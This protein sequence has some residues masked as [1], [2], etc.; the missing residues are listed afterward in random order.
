MVSCTHG[1]LFWSLMF[2]ADFFHRVEVWG[3]KQNKHT[4]ALYNLWANIVFWC[5]QNSIFILR[6]QAARWGWIEG[7]SRRGWSGGSVRWV[8][9]GLGGG[10]VE[11]SSCFCFTGVELRFFIFRQFLLHVHAAFSMQSVHQ[12][13]SCSRLSIME[14]L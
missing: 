9:G 3:D 5:H 10:V 8:F 13:L 1:N 6:G 12:A 2:A 14:S 11:C 4:A 7:G